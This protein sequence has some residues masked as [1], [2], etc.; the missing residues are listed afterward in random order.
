MSLTTPDTIRTLQ[1]KLYAKAKQEP[2]YR[3]YALYDKLYRADILN[4]AWR[5]V[6]ANRGSPGVDGISFEAIED[7]NG[8]ETL[9]RELAQDL[10]EKTYR[11]QPVRRVMIPKAEGSMRPL[12]IATI[13]DRVA[14]MAVKLVIEP[15]FEADFCAHSYGFRPKRSAHDAVDDI[16]NTLWAGYTQVIDADLSKYFDSIPHAKLMVVVAERIV[17]GGILHLIRQWLKAP[18]ISEDDNGVKKTVGGGK[19]SNKGTPQ[20][21]VISPLLANCYLHILDRVWQR[22]QLKEKLKAHL[23]RYAD[24]FVVLC[25][26]GVEEPLKVVRHVLERQGLSLNEAKTQVV[27]ATQASFDFLG[28]SIRMRRGRRT[29]KPYPHV[30]PSEKS[31]MKI[32]TKLTALTGRELTPIALEKI[33]KNVNRS[34]SGWVNYFHYRN[35]NQVLEKVKTHAEQR[36]RRHLMKRHKVKDRGIGEG[37]FPSCHLYERYGL[38]K[39]STVAGW[40]S[41][42]ASA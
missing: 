4:H 31:L 27:D 6:K 40:R 7:G 20:G 30:C 12:G 33:V 5:L 23:V 18:V 36:L 19:A 25:C 32:K 14:Q 34:L 39:V 41:A 21:G 1:R 11:A 16:A 3:F 2:A 26:K 37:R 13:R 24:D 8:V 17:D 38:Y 15:I 28:F 35:S 42:H 10:K 9:L 29:G 22:Q